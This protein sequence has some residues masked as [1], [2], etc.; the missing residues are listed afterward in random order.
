MEHLIAIVEG[1]LGG[2]LA[3]LAIAKFLAKTIVQH[4]LDKALKSYEFQLSQKADVLKMQLS[5]FAHEQ[6]VALSR[7][8]AQGA[9]AIHA[10]Y[11]ALRTWINPTAEIISGSP[12]RGTDLESHL[13]FYR[14]RC[15]EAH[16][17]SKQLAQVLADHAIYVDSELYEILAKHSADC[18]RAVAEVLVPLRQGEAEG[19][20]VEKIH[21]E[22]EKKRT[23]LITT[24]HSTLSPTNQSI[25]EKL[26]S[27]LG[28]LR[29]RRA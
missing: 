13:G 2:T 27:T 24:Y 14:H 17:A 16:A 7:I 28:T 10:I 5:I 20:E 4:Q 15:E 26:R 3:T 25:T 6:N 29:A 21:N 1:C 23:A 8:D 9:Q 22:M 18:G 19:W 11:T 12:L